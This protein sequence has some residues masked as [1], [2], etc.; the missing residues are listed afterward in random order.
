M[1]AF[2]LPTIA[3]LVYRQ[4]MRRSRESIELARSLAVERGR[5]KRRQQLVARSL[6]GLQEE[7]AH[8]EAIDA[9]A[10]GP[11]LR[12]LEWEVDAL[13][14]VIAGTRKLAFVNVDLGV[15]L[16]TLAAPLREVGIDVGGPLG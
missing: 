9:D 1:I 10:R 16:A 15:E 6:A 7:I 13:S 3:V 11:F 8:I 5:G 12:R 4:I 2:V 14:T